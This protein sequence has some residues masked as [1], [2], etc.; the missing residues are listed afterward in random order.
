PHRRAVAPHVELAGEPLDDVDG[1]VAAVGRVVVARRHVDPERPLGRVTEPVRPQDVAVDHVLVEAA[2]EPAS[3]GRV[4]HLTL[5]RQACCEST[6]AAGGRLPA[7]WTDA[8]SWPRTPTASGWSRGWPRRTS[9]ACSRS[10]S[11]TS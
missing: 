9:T 1:R 2:G 5:H 6:G 3:P 7:V 8:R 10:R 11:S 4:K